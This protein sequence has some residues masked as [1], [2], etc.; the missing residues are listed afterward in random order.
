VVCALISQLISPINPLPDDLLV[1]VFCCQYFPP[2]TIYFGS[3]FHFYQLLRRMMSTAT[4]SSTP[5]WLREDVDVV[6]PLNNS[7]SGNRPAEGSGAVDSERKSKVVYWI[8]KLTTMFLCALIVATAVIGI[9][10][11]AST[12]F[13]LGNMPL[14]CSFS[15]H[16]E[17]IDGVEAS[18]KIFVAVYMIFF[19]SLLFTFE[20]MEIKP[21]EWV[22]HLLRRNFGFLY[23]TMGKS[24]Y[25]VL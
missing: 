6:Q 3:S 16:T 12:I 1:G 8:L 24:L 21:T 4:N 9:G 25:I 14:L 15:L 2:N 18:G 22:D 5:P 7:S 23:G 20:L 17:Y 13:F 11:Y 10:K 19:S